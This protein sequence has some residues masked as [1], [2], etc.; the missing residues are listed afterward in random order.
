MLTELVKAAESAPDV[1]CVGPKCYFHG[2]RQRLW[3]AG[4]VLRFRESITR[5]RGYG[6]IDRGQYD[7]DAEVDYVNGCAIL[8]R[9]A[10]AEAAG[11]WDDVF[12]ICVDDA[13]FCTRVKRHG[14]RCLYAHR[15]GLQ[16]GAELPV[17]PE[18]SDL[19]P[20]L[21]P[22]LAVAH[23]LRLQRR[24]LPGGLATRAAQGEPGR[25]GGQGP[26]DPGG[27]ADAGPTAAGLHST[28][29]SQSRRDR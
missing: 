25:G 9:R 26:G 5:E 16:P 19:R 20:A 2:D 29:F 7:R 10:A 23:L 12:Y 14:F 24:R 15:A 3:S 13:D 11:M 8:I 21:R 27:F 1:G 18:R 22:G 17:R 28:C 4:G 6:E